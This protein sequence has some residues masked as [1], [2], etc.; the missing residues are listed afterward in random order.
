MNKLIFLRF[1]K[2][3]FEVVFDNLFD[4][5]LHSQF[6]RR[7]AIPAIRF[8]SKIVDFK[9]I[10]LFNMAKSAVKYVGVEKG[11]TGKLVKDALIPFQKRWI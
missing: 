11:G 3:K 6:L 2:L 7:F 9:N 1:R 5:F 4:S 10:T 8:P